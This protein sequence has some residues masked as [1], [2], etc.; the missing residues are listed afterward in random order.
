MSRHP[1]LMSKVSAQDVDGPAFP[2]LLARAKQSIRVWVSFTGY[3]LTV[4]ALTYALMGL[5][6]AVVACVEIMKQ[7][8][9][10]KIVASLV[11]KL[12]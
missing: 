6:M 11:A 5:A 1:M 9:V 4:F 12:L 2:S 8:H 3:L 7:D 10:R